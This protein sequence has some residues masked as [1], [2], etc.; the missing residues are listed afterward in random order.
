LEDADCWVGVEPE[1]PQAVAATPTK[2][3][4]RAMAPIRLDLLL[5]TIGKLLM[6]A[7]SVVNFQ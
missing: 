3:A 4:D 1:L 2:A 5:R 6:F 7:Y